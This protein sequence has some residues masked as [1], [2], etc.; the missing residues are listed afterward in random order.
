MVAAFDLESATILSVHRPHEMLETL[1]RTARE[2]WM[3]ALM[4]MPFVLRLI[5]VWQEFRVLVKHSP[6]LED[7]LYYYLN[8]ARNVCSGHGFTADGNTPTTGFQFL[9]EMLCIVVTFPFSADSLLPFRIMLTLEV[10]ISLGCLIVLMDTIRLFLGKAESLIAGFVFSWW[11]LVFRHGNNGLETALQI[12]MILVLIRFSYDFFVYRSISRLA[13]FALASAVSIL[14][15]IDMLAFPAA[16]IAVVVISR[17]RKLL[18][19]R[20]AF[21]AI[22]GVTLPVATAVAVYFLF[23]YSI[24]GHIL[25]DSGVAVKQL[26]Q[27]Y[28]KNIH[29]GNLLLSG[30]RRALS[31]LLG[32][33]PYNQLLEVL[34]VPLH[35]RLEFTAVLVILSVLFFIRKRDTFSHELR[36]QIL[37]AAIYGVILVSFY[38]FYLP[39]LWYF[40]RYLFT[41]VVLSLL[42]LAPFIKD[43]FL[44]IGTR[45][46]RP[47]L[48]LLIVSSA[49]WYTLA[50]TGRWIHFM[51][52]ATEQIPDASLE[53]RPLSQTHVSHIYDIGRWVKYNVA[54]PGRIAMWQNGLAEYVSRRNILHLDGIVNR[55]ALD[56]WTSNRLDEYLKHNQ[57]DY[58]IDFQ[59]FTDIA[60]RHSQHPAESYRLIG[61]SAPTSSGSPPV[62]MYKVNY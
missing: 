45:V 46:S 23:N 20:E 27:E 6:L 28:G 24:N 5:L 1:F 52:D 29:G 36:Y 10:L 33:Q 60:L 58:L 44:R 8:I 11:L 56:A 34:G 3:L 16:F 14:V 25:P 57:I 49:V 15:R 7:D 50:G 61:M 53:D 37:L 4:G 55:N 47:V 59:F 22:A 40:S 12:L 2:R 54:P 9:H 26:T 62:A 32:D 41:V 42:L 13:L 48:A 19:A 31:V 43:L 18:S 38:S 39:A 35:P 51:L 30:P 21:T 17:L